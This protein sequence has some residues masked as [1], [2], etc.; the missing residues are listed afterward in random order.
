MKIVSHNPLS[1]VR[2]AIFEVVLR[3]HVVWNVFFGNH[4]IT[5][6]GNF[7]Y[8]HK[9]SHKYFFQILSIIMVTH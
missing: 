2:P 8:I 5:H 4:I 9:A 6:S 3:E 7:R 1:Q